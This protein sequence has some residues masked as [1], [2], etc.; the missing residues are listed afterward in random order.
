L[1]NLQVAPYTSIKNL[2]KNVTLIVLKV[3]HYLHKNVTFT[4]LKMLHYLYQNVTFTGLK[5]AHNDT[6]EALANSVHL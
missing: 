5:M 3:S 1:Y 4:L 6:L 2:Y